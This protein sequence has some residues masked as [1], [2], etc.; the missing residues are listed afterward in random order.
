MGRSATDGRGLHEP[1]V[2]ALHKGFARVLSLDEL[3]AE[4]YCQRV[5]SR[6]YLRPVDPVDCG[7]GGRKSLL[8]ADLD[9]RPVRVLIRPDTNPL[10]EGI[11]VSQIS[12]AKR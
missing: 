1:D 6:C 8:R 10:I 4:H 5:A 7:D 3:L 9:H 11:L 12:S 2:K